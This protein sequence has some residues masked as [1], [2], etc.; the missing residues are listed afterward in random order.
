MVT[1]GDPLEGR[2]AVEMSHEGRPDATVG[3]NMPHAVLRFNKQ[4]T[5][6]SHQRACIDR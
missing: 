6:S 4:L 1:A 2:F 3:V 5:L